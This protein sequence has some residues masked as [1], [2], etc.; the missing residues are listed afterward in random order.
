MPIAPLLEPYASD[1]VL[2]LALCVYR[3][4]RGEPIDAKLGVAWTIRNRCALAPAQGFKHDISG[5]ILKPW[6][7]SSF[8]ES[9]PN[10]KVYPE[11]S[12][13]PA[14]RQAWADSLTVARSVEADP[15][16]GGIFYF[17]RPLTAPPA[18]W[19]EVQHCA[20]IGG[21]QFYRLA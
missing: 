3:E 7:F 15:T 18:A 12:D 11:E 9:D 8:M 4:A 10:S 19:G 5:N 17:S 21:L 1:P 6:A 20:T 13:P 2:L 14:D 16:L